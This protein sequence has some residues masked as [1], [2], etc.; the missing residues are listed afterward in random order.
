MEYYN[1]FSK[2]Q[3]G[4]SYEESAP[5]T[6]YVPRKFFSS[7]SN[8]DYRS[9]FFSFDRSRIEPP[10]RPRNS[11]IFLPVIHSRVDDIEARYRRTRSV[12]ERACSEQTDTS[13]HS[14]NA[15][16]EPLPSGAAASE[17]REGST[18]SVITQEKSTSQ[19][20]VDSTSSESDTTKSDSGFEGG[21]SGDA[22][23]KFEFKRQRAKRHYVYNPKP[24]AVRSTP[25]QPPK[26]AKLSNEAKMKDEAYW[27]HREYNNAAA[28]RSRTNRREKEMEILR[29]VKHLSN[30]NEKLIA[31]VEELER[32]NANLKAL[33]IENGII[34]SP[35]N[36]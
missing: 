28:K 8:N 34:I 22:G 6:G 32:K 16:R 15:G 23:K 5:A 10:E 1:R 3:Y 30:E 27:R 18:Q 9:D 36:F 4:R 14:E 20:G 17:P 24:I 21:S 19:R 29:R 35:D 33:L 31:K 26:V 25:T 2:G 12:I 7:E 11:A 13:R